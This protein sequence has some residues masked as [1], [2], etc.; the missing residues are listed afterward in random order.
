MKQSH[1]YYSG[2]VQGIGFRY[3]VEAVARRLGLTGWVRNLSDGRVEIWSKAIRTNR[4]VAVGVDRRFD[5]YIR[6]KAVTTT[7]KTEG[8]GE[9]TITH[10]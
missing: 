5:G 3:T 8:F 2:T 7:E 9:F 1:I 4:S 10:E 6:D